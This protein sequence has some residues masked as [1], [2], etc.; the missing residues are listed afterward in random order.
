MG[1][2]KGNAKV[3]RMIQTINERL[4]TSTN[5]LISKDQSGISNILFALRSKKGPDG[6]SVFEKQNGRKPN[7][8]KLRLIEKCISDQDPR[9]F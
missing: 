2:H 7:A 3:G 1:D 5:I 9:R 4:R 6:K 8:E